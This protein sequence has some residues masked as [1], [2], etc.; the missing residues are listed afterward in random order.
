M[1]IVFSRLLRVNCRGIFYRRSVVAVNT[2]VCVIVAVAENLWPVLCKLPRGAHLADLSKRDATGVIL[3]V[4]LRL[5]TVDAG[6]H[7][8]AP[9]IRRKCCGGQLPPYFFILLL[10]VAG[11]TN[12]HGFTPCVGGTISFFYLLLFFYYDIMPAAPK[13]RGLVQSPCQR[14]QAT[15]QRTNGDNCQPSK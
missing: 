6:V 1:I 5:V 14:L 12:M 4:C 10:S 15:A 7:V 13:A 9:I 11:S 8:H 3:P 2:L